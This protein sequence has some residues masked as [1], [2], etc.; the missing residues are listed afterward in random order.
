M[1]SLPAWHGLRRVCWLRPRS[2][3]RKEPRTGTP[4]FPHL[5]FMGALSGFLWFNRPP[6]RIFMGDVGSTFLGFYLGLCSLGLASEDFYGSQRWAVVPCAFFS[7]LC[8][9]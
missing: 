5:M 8:T 2:C 1:H 3:D 6:A 7:F 4:V 9:I